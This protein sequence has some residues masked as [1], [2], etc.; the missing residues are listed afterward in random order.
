MWHLVLHMMV[1][2]QV[3]MAYPMD[4]WDKSQQRLLSTLLGEVDDE[5]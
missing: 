1:A 3:V 4:K 5:A 2:M